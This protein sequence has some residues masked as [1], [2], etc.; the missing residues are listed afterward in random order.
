MT[1]RPGPGLDGQTYRERSPHSALGDVVS[2]VWVQAVGPGAPAYAH[3]TVPN[4][5]VE[6]MCRIGEE[7]RVVGPRTAPAVDA[8]APGATVVGVRFHPGAASPLLGVSAAELV[9]DSVEV[10]AVWGRSAAF[11]GEQVAE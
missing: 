4:G 5:S 9:D 8:L 10:E 3:R 7:P 11:L 2:S 6:L 1:R